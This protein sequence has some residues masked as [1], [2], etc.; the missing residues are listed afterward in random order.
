MHYRLSY[1]AIN[2]NELSNIVAISARSDHDSSAFSHN[3]TSMLE[4]ALH[5]AKSPMGHS[6]TS[7]WAASCI[8]VAPAPKRAANVL[9]FV[10]LVLK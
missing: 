5:M 7:S 10:F 3:T 8:Q 6:Y 4:T 2:P 9:A 1:T